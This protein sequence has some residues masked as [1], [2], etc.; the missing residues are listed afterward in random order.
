VVDEVCDVVAF[1]GEVLPN[2]TVTVSLCPDQGQRAHM[3]I[4]DAAGR[5]RRYSDLLPS[6]VYLPM[7]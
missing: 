2:A 7:R 4:Y 3:T 1:E 6:N 5:A